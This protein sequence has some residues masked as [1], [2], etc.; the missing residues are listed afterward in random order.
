M[1][2]KEHQVLLDALRELR[3]ECGAPVHLKG[4]TLKTL[5]LA[6]AR[7]AAADPERLGKLIGS[8]PEN[9]AGN[10]HSVSLALLK[11]GE[12]GEGRIARGSVQGIA[13]QHS[14]LIL[15]DDVY[16][17]DA[18]IVDPT[19][20]P[21]TRYEMTIAVDVAR[22][23]TNRPH[24]SGRI[25][26]WGRPWAHSASY[27]DL[28]VPL[29]GEAKA[30]MDLIGPLD[31]LGWMQLAGAPMQGW[32]AGE[33]IAAMRQTPALKACVPVDIAGML[34]AENPGGLYR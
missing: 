12:F 31:I 21:A 8:A 10:C 28:A 3:L 16:D 18:V 4:P 27:I 2:T 5:T 6:Q 26:D 7:D 29:A 9:W 25:W 13:S 15:S 14:W 23:L 22:C 34:T 11:T 20:L 19:I 1:I 32:P 30:F 24:G 33:I 17:Q